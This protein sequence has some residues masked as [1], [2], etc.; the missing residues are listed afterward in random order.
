MINPE[1]KK[2]LEKQGYR[3]AGSHSAVKICGWTKKTIL[4]KGTC[5]KQK[6]YG[7]NTHQCLQM[8]TSMSCANR[9]IFCWRDYKSP[10]S[11][12][13]KWN[14]DEPEL[15]LEEAKKAHHKLLIG[16]F[17]N[18]ETD[19]KALME[20]K[21]IKH[22]ALSLTGE[23]INYPKVN[24]LINLMHKQRISTFMVTN[25]QNPESIKKLGRVTQLYLSV[26]GADKETLKET[27]KP[28]FAD[29]WERLMQSLEAL[30]EKKHRT[31][32]RITLIKEMNDKNPEKYAELIKKAEPDFV[33]VKAYMF[34]GAS[35]ERLK[36]ENMPTHTETVKFAEKI[37]EHLPDYELMSEHKP[38]RVA[39][40]THKNLKKDGRWKTWIDFEAFF[41]E[42]QEY[43]TDTPEENILIKK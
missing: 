40:L 27:G 2:A 38:S 28:L 6:F 7:I 5:Y 23:P 3:T 10:V 31:C 17:G 34:I 13:W 9:C 16:F 36:R 4:G 29:Y 33:E 26:D 8:T 14:I 43:N 19:K 25:G 39:L 24:E 21:E 32:I 18:D 11:K 1:I 35:K 30:K 37:K 22:A 12:D 20:S 15:V 41:E 42:K